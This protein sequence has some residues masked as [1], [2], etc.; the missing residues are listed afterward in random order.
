[1]TQDKIT[2]FFEENYTTLKRYLLKRFNYLNHYDAEDVIQHTLTK[3]IQKRVNPLSITHMSS[4]IYTAIQNGAKDH[5]KRNRL[6]DI[7]Q[8]IEQATSPSPEVQILNQELYRMINQAI[9]QLDDKSKYVFIETEIKGRTYEELVL[10][11]GEKLGTLL[12]RKSRAKKK[13]QVMLN[14]YL[15]RTPH[16]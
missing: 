12:S 10:E 2:D 7:T 4:Y 16:E 5:F 13:I 1:M 3:L 6:L 15:R 14:D 9:D 11:T 8:E